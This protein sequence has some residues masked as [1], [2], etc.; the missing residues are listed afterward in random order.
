MSLAA[1]IEPSAELLT[2][3]QNMPGLAGKKLDISPVSGGLTN[4]NWRVGVGDDGAEDRAYF[5]KVPGPGT[6]E[7]INRT[8]VYAAS[9][10]AASM[11]V[12]P[13]ALFFDPETGIEIDEFLGGYKPC[14]TA[15]LAHEEISDQVVEIYRKWHAG[16]ALPE[17]KTMLD[18]VDEHREQVQRDGT[19][20]P[21]WVSQL[22][23]TYDEAA[24]R[25]R[26]SGLDIVPCHNDA[27]PGNYMR[28]PARSMRL[29]D[30]D[31]ASNNERAYEL[32]GFV[33][34]FFFD[35]EQT[36]HAIE[37]YFG[38]CDRELWS[39]VQVCR[40]IA[41]V[42]WGLWGLVNAVAWNSDFDYYKYGLWKLKRADFFSHDPDWADD[43]GSI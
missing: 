20:V 12:G 6:D 8:T 17:T 22:L 26:A 39:R 21:S 43:L 33:C 25:F 11:G 7:F 23:A 29:I 1:A 3:L 41:D 5:V 16:A 2:V 32:G 13:E 19:A 9:R 36:R 4:V 38:H 42:K 34:E 37:V 31:Y 27:M 24:A 28:A 18:L 30:Y 35:R 10:Q 15:D 14:T 40:V